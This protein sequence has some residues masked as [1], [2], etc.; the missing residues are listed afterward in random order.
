M[1]IFFLSKRYYTNKDLLVDRFGR[2]YHLPVGLQQLGNQVKCCALDY[3]NSSASV[4]DYEGVEFRSIPISLT[5]L[6]QAYRYIKERVRQTRPDVIVASGD[7]HIGYFGS[8]LA[9]EVGASFAFDVYDYYPSFGTNRIPGMGRLFET[10]VR[11]ADITLCASTP[12]IETLSPLAKRVMLV[13]N[14]VDRQLFFPRDKQSARTNTGLPLDAPLVG[15]FGSMTPTRGPILFDAVG[16]IKSD[17]PGITL[18]L[19]GKLQGIS[20]PQESII[21]LGELPQSQLPP[22]ISACDVATVPYSRSS[23]NDMSGACKIAEY[24]ACGTPVV[25][26]RIAGHE[27][28][29][30]DTPEAMCRPD[31]IDF[32]QALLR[33]LDRPRI[34][35]FPSRLDWVDIS[36]RLVSGLASLRT[37]GI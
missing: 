21:Y 26:T 14:G 20:L 17:K 13:E 2:L 35:K 31:A 15:Y 19:A 1:K 7:S 5:R 34:A 25:A 23:F 16:R 18:V 32:A 29:F 37:D 24:L 27:S 3:R 30:L 22:L 12:L 36:S 28:D 11:N 4:V 9:E 33:Q 6:H 10:A 8:R